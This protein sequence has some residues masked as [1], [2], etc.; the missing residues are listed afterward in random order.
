MIAKQLLSF[1]LFGASRREDDDPH[2]HSASSA[3]SSK[4]KGSKSSETTKEKSRAQQKKPNVEFH[5]EYERPRSARTPRVPL[6][7]RPLQRHPSIPEEV[8]SGEE[9]VLVPPPLPPS[10]P[11]PADRRK[12]SKQHVGLQRHPNRKISSTHHARPVRRM[13]VFE[14][15][16]YGGSMHVHSF[17]PKIHTA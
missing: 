5:V 3:I 15:V 10:L 4:T 14:D 6:S 2:K 13:S 12:H 11:P 1:P 9:I 8:E 16:A 7:E 17:Y